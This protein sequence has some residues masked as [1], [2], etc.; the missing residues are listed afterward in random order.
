MP[1]VPFSRQKHWPWPMPHVPFSSQFISLGLCPMHYS[2]A[3]TLALAYAPCAMLQPA[4]RP[5]PMHHVPFGNQTIGP[6]LCHMYHSAANNIGP[7]PTQL[8]EDTTSPY[9]KPSSLQ[10][11]WPPQ[12]MRAT[13]MDACMHARHSLVPYG[14]APPAAQKGIFS[15]N[16]NESTLQK[17]KY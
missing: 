1:H 7:G 13:N 12:S 8:A 4:H 15:G 14:P 3:D 9:G 16:C 6:G 5:W 2:P 17:K 11:A 10:C